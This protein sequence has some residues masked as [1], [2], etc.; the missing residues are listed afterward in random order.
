MSLLYADTSALVRAYVADE[1]D[2]SALRKLLLDGMERVV[3]SEIARVEFA[4]AIRGAARAGRLRNWRELLAVFDAHCADG[5]PISLLELRGSTVLPAAYRLVLDRGIRTL[6]AIHL[7]VAIEEGP[8][9]A[10]DGDVVFVTRDRAQAR[11]ARAL[12]LAV[13]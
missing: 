3:T 7:A 6:D 5:H 1:P 13:R 4:A 11:A 9:L 8:A 12:G 10:D 2:H